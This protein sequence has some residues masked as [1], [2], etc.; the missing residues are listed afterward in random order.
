MR[1]SIVLVLIMVLTS[2][3]LFPNNSIK[4]N[5]T[6]EKILY[7]SKFEIS[8]NDDVDIVHND[9]GSTDIFVTKIGEVKVVK[10]G[11]R[12]MQT[13][14]AERAKYHLEGVDIV[15]KAKL[16]ATFL[17]DGSSATC[18]A[19][20]PTTEIYNSNWYL[21]SSSDGR[22]GNSAYMSY[23]FKKT[24]GSTKSGSITISC[25]GDGTIYSS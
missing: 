4:A 5:S 9:D 2:V 3:L 12:V 23:T 10:V 24:S 21:Y 6:K 16:E 18:I 8:D 13:K 15:W 7:N 1:K 19:H 17:Y 22:S 11:D 25:A 20:N 14:T